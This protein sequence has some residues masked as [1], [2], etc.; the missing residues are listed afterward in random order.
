[1]D[2]KKNK[3][4]IGYVMG[5]M[6][7]SGGNKIIYEHANRLSEKGFDVYLLHLNDGKDR[8]W[9]EINPK[10]KV[11]QF[12]ETEK[13]IDKIDIIIATF[14]ETFWNIIDL[15][16]NIKKA[17]F[18]QSDERRFYEKNSLGE[19]LSNATYTFKNIYYYT[20]AKWM[21]KWLKDEYKVDAPVFPIKIDKKAFFPDPD[22][23]LKN[24]N[25]KKIVLV[26]GNVNTPMKGVQDA[27][28]ALKGVDCEKWLLTNAAGDMP[29]FTK[30]FDKIFSQ[31]P[32]E[33][34]R[35]IYSSAD[36]LVK[37]SYFEGSPLPHMEAMACGTAL[38][39]T[40]C[41][42]VDEYCRHLENSYIVKVGNVG[43]IKDAVELLIRDDNLRKKL[44]KAGLDLAKSTLYDWDSVIEDE[45]KYFETI[46]GSDQLGTFTVA[47]TLTR[48][49]F[50][51]NY[52]ISHM[53]LNKRLSTLEGR[54]DSIYRKI[55][56]IGWPYR[57]GQ[58]ILRR[59]N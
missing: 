5:F 53:D 23:S 22:P 50:E 13:W 20:E 24:S 1:M 47:E 4:T 38:L 34:I 21:Q 15:P 42:G 44:V 57:A 58:K 11:M 59:K 39:T 27:A 49:T 19:Y 29:E 17:Y 52:F 9:F 55:K 48:K 10:V 28:E 2:N 3:P 16:S 18:V 6:G 46:L 8:G 14:N 36:I 12:Q 26:E 25:G 37:P 30:I 56:I 31:P 51:N 45:I 32:Q 35:K 43:Q 41:T 7:L 54:F 40:D 33:K